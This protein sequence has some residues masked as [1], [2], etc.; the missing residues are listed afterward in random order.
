MVYMGRRGIL[1]RADEP[2]HRAKRYTW[3][4]MKK[5]PIPPVKPYAMRIGIGG[6]L[7]RLVFGER[8][9]FMS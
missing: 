1:G 5:A 4:H 8:S 2:L 6:I 9:F 7:G 3:V